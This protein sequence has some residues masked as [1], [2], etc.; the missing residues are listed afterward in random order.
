MG[1][2][3]QNNV[4]FEPVGTHPDFQ[5]RGLG[6]AVMTE[7]LRRLKDRGMERAIVCTTAENTPG[8]KLYEAVGFRIINR[9][10]LF[11]KKLA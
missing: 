5:R 10:G 7:A 6:K 3:L 11:E 4:M 9:L 8:I 1:T 2:S